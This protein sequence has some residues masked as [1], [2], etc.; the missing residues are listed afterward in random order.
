MSQEE[1]VGPSSA[2]I[3]AALKDPKLAHVDYSV[4]Q[5]EE[6][7]IEDSSPDADE[8]G[9]A[10]ASKDDASSEDDKDTDKPSDEDKAS[11]KEKSK[12]KPEVETRIRDLTHAKRA[13]ELR[14][15]ELEEENRRLKGEK[16]S[17]KR[18][19]RYEYATDQDFEDA[20]L[21]WGKQEAIKETR[22]QQ[23]KQ[24]YDEVY[25]SYTDKL[26]DFISNTEEW[27]E[28]M[29]PDVVKV[30]QKTASKEADE[31]MLE[32]DNPGEVLF[33]LGQDDDLLD[34]FAKAGPIKQTKML[35]KLD[36]QMSKEAAPSQT[37]RQNNGSNPK[38]KATA[39]LP[40]GNVPSSG[41][42][43]DAQI[44]AALNARRW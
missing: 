29:T 14:A 34:E 22:K 7:V 15:Q 13:A 11:K 37:T 3:D 33:A 9:K 8:D 10:D 42:L 17:V 26:E 35:L 31:A 20:L 25:T 36:A 30:I 27:A 5:V 12:R 16:E 23:E 18:P 4:K 32:L 44:E 40:K 24:R 6:D 19:T 28:V 41:G 43:T 1:V 38:A 2:E 39:D 21:Q